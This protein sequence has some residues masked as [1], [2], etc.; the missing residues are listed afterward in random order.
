[1]VPDKSYY[2]ARDHGYLAMDYE[3][4]FEMVQTLP[5]ARYQDL[6][7][8]LTLSDYY[9]TDTHWRQERIVKVAQ[10][11]AQALGVPGPQEQDFT[12]VALERPFYGVYY[13]QAALPMLSETL[14]YMESEVLKNA[15]VKNFENGKTGG[16]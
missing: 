4:L 8:S 13:G 11:L 14:Y 9:F 3:T 2:L 15:V 16:V 5:W 10:T 7:E 6:T 12:P 1:M